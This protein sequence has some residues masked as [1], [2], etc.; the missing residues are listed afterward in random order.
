MFGI[1]SSII[2][3]VG[4]FNSSVS[5]RTAEDQERRFAKGKGWKYYTDSHGVQRDI[6]TNR[7][8]PMSQLCPKPILKIPT[9]R[10]I[11]K[12]VL[13]DYSKGYCLEELEKC[14][15]IEYFATSKDYYFKYLLTK[16]CPK[17][18]GYEICAE[19]EYVYR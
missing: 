13:F 11:W 7:A 8:V 10:M 19:N 17:G 4:L 2:G 18:C 16:K 15:A 12:I 1:I 5:Q 6:R 9:G 14:P 3:A